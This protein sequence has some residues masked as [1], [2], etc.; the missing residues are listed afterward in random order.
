MT[1]QPLSTKPI[2]FRL[3]VPVMEMLLAH[4]H[5]SGRSVGEVAREIVTTGLLDQGQADLEREVAEVG[6]GMQLLRGD[7]A[8]VLETLL[9]NLTDIPKEDVQAFISEKLR[10]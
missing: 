6:E 8:T 2:S 7:L 5:D 9:L 4:A 10:R 3:P 1:S